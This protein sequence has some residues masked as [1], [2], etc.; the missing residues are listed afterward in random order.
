LDTPNLR[1]P[2]PFAKS[3]FLAAAD[4]KHGAHFWLRLAEKTYLPEG[5]FHMSGHEGQFVSIIPE[6]KLVVVRLGLT[7]KSGAWKQ[8]QFVSKIRMTL[9]D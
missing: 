5:T 9:E 6:E 4:K 2:R 1:Y 7:Q 8:E 3:K